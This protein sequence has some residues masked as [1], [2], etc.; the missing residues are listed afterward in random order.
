MYTAIQIFLNYFYCTSQKKS[1]NTSQ[2]NILNN[3]AIIDIQSFMEFNT[4]KNKYSG[5]YL[6]NASNIITELYA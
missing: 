2:C 4:I 3:R 6:L 5:K 1:P